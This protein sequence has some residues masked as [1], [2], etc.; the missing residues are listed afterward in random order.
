MSPPQARKGLHSGRLT[1]ATGTSK[2]VAANRKSRPTGR[3]HCPDRRMPI[4]RAPQQKPKR[5]EE[6]SQKNDEGGAPRLRRRRTLALLRISAPSTSWSIGIWPRRSPSRGL[7]AHGPHRRA[8]KAGL[9]AGRKYRTSATS[10]LPPSPF[11]A[12]ATGSTSA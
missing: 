7:D 4:R 9:D 1:G 6:R 2:A 11:P 12:S 8:V 10:S 3:L 5:K